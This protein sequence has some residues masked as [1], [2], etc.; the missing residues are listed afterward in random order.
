MEPITILLAEDETLLLVD[1]E[2]GLREAGFM[3]LAV[4]SGKKAIEHLKA[5]ES[6]IAG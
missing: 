5:A 6:S 1:F 3:V 4:T 2:D